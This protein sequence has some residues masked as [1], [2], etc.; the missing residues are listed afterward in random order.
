MKDINLSD[1][2]EILLSGDIKYFRFIE[3]KTNRLYLV[4][5]Y[6]KELLEDKMSD[7][8]KLNNIDE[9][10]KYFLNKDSSVNIFEFIPIMEIKKHYD[11]INNMDDIGRKNLALIIKEAKNLQIAYI[12]F[13]YFFVQT[14]DNL[15]YYANY[16]KKNNISTLKN[17]KIIKT[18]YPADYKKI[19]K[20][21]KTYRAFIYHNRTIKYDDIKVYIEN[22]LLSPTKDVS[23]IE[24]I[25]SEFLKEQ[26]EK[27]PV[28]G[29]ELKDETSQKNNQ[30]K[31]E[32]KSLS[33]KE[34]MQTLQNQVIENLEEKNSN[35]NNLIELKDKIKKENE[36]VKNNDDK[37]ISTKEKRKKLSLFTY[38]FIG[39]SLGIVLAA[40]TIIIGNF[41]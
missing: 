41:I 11:I 22:P 24:G 10:K 27:K 8:N 33:E 3:K 26:V 1:F 5:D 21:I 17:L 4:E 39:F 18:I 2:N 32:K 14:K 38:C 19:V 20:D 13:D 15:L 16:N 34:D 31:E 9:V 37:L 40:I 7:L 30:N 28:L 23:L 12:N 35:N 36:I 6:S 29:F 25:R